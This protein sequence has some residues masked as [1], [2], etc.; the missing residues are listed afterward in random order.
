MIPRG[1]PVTALCRA[2][3]PG[4]IPAEGPRPSSQAVKPPRECLDLTA[5]GR[6]PA[7]FDIQH[8]TFNIRHSIFDI[9]YST[10]AFRKY[11]SLKSR[12]H[13]P[14]REL[15]CHGSKTG[16]WI[17]AGLDAPGETGFRVFSGVRKPVKKS[18]KS[19]CFI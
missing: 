1:F 17:Q 5:A 13:K 2:A 7:D 11:P 3:A 14:S 8:S 6:R 12:N 9:Q 19:C 10:F 18:N 15:R 16:Q 4:M